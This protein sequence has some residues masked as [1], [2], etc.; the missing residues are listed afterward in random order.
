M[1]ENHEKDLN[2]IKEEFKS[3]IQDNE[4]T[5]CKYEKLE[6]THKENEIKFKTEIEELTMKLSNSKSELSEHQETTEKNKSTL[7]QVINQLRTDLSS[8]D[9]KLRDSSNSLIESNKKK[10]RRYKE[11]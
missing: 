8:K 1:K 5:I 9:S 11:T 2:I 10:C 3:I 6:K 7:Q 4:F